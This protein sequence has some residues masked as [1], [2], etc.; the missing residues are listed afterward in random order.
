M[1][2]E[3]PNIRSTY[4]IDW[5]TARWGRGK[6]APA[7]EYVVVHFTGSGGK[8]GTAA[9]TYK[10]WL[11]R[12]K[13]TRCNTHYLVDASGVYECVDPKK[14]ACLFA[15]VSIPADRHI[16]LYIDGNGEA[17]PQACSH[18]KV[19]GNYNTI[20]IE[21]CSAKRTP[22][23]KAPN[24]YMDTDFYFPDTTYRNLVALSA[25]LLDSFGIPLE[26][27]IMHHNI[28]GKLCPAMWCNNRGA[29]EQWAAFK[30]DVA[31]VLNKPVM[32]ADL[33]AP[34]GEGTESGTLVTG[35]VRVKEGDPIYLDPHGIV[36][37]YVESDRVIPYTFERDGMYY[38]SLGYVKGGG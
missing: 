24:A 33:P 12:S 1:A 26:N 11:L 15:C 38:T 21:A 35:N 31:L 5:H 34:D 36:V 10:D 17:S 29:F 32:A 6:I 16:Q 23:R 9:A 30:N 20:N 18:I 2:V 8:G 37:G 13:N 3:K 19:A 28:S 14:Y 27:L 25:W 4:V 22:V 7:P